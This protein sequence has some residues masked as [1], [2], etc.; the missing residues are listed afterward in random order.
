VP[1]LAKVANA[2]TEAE[3]GASANGERMRLTSAHERHAIAV[4]A[5]ATVGTQRC[6]EL[7]AELAT[8]GA[9][10]EPASATV[11]EAVHITRLRDSKRVLGATGSADAVL[12]EQRVH[13]LWRAQVQIVAVAEVAVRARTP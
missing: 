12:A 10:A 7:W 13:K 4:G 6:D 8:R 1:E 2:P 9:V 5:H 11:A 3:L